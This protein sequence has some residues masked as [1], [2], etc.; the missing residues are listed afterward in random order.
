MG[1]QEFPGF[2]KKNIEKRAQAEVA[3]QSRREMLQEEVNRR[4]RY[5][6]YPIDHLSIDHRDEYYIELKPAIDFYNQGRYEAALKLFESKPKDPVRF[7]KNLIC[8]FHGPIGWLLMFNTKMKK[9]TFLRFCIASCQYHLYDYEKA[10]ST[11]ENDSTEETIYLKA[12]CQF[13]L[14]R[15]DQAKENFKKAFYINPRLLELGYPYNEKEAV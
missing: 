3:A 7:F 5:I 2:H 9:D 1:K 4:C 14:E 11:V 10:L 12:W 6:D 13:K 8:T 15:H